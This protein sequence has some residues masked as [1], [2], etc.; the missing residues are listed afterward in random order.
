[1]EVGPPVCAVVTSEFNVTSII[2]VVTHLHLSTEV[3]KK[4]MDIGLPEYEFSLE[5]SQRCEFKIWNLSTAIRKE[6]FEYLN[7]SFYDKVES[8][9]GKE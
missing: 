7:G 8:F 5:Y 9:V 6:M 4:C 2:T 1:M 3:K